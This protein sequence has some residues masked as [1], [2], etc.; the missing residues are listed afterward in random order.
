MVQRVWLPSEDDPAPELTLS[1][2]DITFAFE[3]NN[4]EGV[5][6]QVLI[7]EFTIIFYFLSGTCEIIFTLKMDVTV[8][9]KLDQK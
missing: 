1:H 5:W 6:S 2:T 3:L 4:T 8:I 9:L 7:L